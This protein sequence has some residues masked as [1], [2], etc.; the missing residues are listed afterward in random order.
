MRQYFLIAAIIYVLLAAFQT[1]LR[2]IKPAYSNIVRRVEALWCLCLGTIAVVGSVLWIVRPG[3]LPSDPSIPIW[4]RVGL[5]ILFALVAILGARGLRAPTYRPDL[6]DTMRVKNTDSWKGELS[7]RADR[8]WWTGE[9]RS[10]P[11]QASAR[12]DV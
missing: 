8:S 5:M 3:T 9:P 1:R 7:R 2:R 11:N 12:Y 4:G 10:H 6:G